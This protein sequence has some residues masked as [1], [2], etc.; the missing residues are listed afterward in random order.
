MLEAVERNAFGMQNEEV[1]LDVLK[2][3]PQSRS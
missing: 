1:D 3:E 2:P